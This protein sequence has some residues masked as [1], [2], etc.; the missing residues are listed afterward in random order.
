MFERL[1]GSQ[2][3]AAHAQA[4]IEAINKVLADHP[5]KVKKQKTAAA[6]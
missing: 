1:Q 3:K 5:V 2:A 4:A 6:T